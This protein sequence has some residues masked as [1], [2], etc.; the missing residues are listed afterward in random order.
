MPIIGI[1]NPVQLIGFFN[2]LW[3]LNSILMGTFNVPGLD[4]LDDT[5]SSSEYILNPPTK[6][7][8]FGYTLGDSKLSDLH[9]VGFFHVL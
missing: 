6:C 9:R 4:G 8:R 5:V 3:Q 1:G 2:R 7:G